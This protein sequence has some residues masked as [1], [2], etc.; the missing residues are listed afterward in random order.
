MKTILALF[1]AVV[2]GSGCF[3]QGISILINPPTNYIGA[4]PAGN[5]AQPVNFTNAANS[6]TGNGGS[7][8]NVDAQSIA[9]FIQNGA[10]SMTPSTTLGINAM[11]TIGGV[12]SANSYK[13]D[14]PLQDGVY[15]FFFNCASVASSSGTNNYLVGVTN[16]VDAFILPMTAT[17]SAATSYYFAFTNVIALTNVKTFHWLMTNSPFNSSVNYNFN[18]LAARQ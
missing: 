8:T 13:I 1:L 16:G 14:A 7:L 4:D 3:G 5:V 11:I 9:F 18:G 2:F 6:F 17:F 10:S 12:S 15:S